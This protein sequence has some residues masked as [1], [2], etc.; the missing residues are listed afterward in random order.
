V[1]RGRGVP[2]ASGTQ[3]GRQARAQAQA[4]GKREEG[5]R[6]KARGTALGASSSVERRVLRRRRCEAA[7]GAAEMGSKEIVIQELT[8]VEE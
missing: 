8:S 6:E 1:T 2:V 4:D 3:R 5:K 7:F